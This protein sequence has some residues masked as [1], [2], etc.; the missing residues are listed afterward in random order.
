MIFLPALVLAGAFVAG[1]DFI[2]HCHWKMADR[3]PCPSAT[4]NT[5]CKTLVCASY[6]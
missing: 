6:R 3:Q 5:I 2:H 1:F 4:R